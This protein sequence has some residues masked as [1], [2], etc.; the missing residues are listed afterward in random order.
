MEENCL[1]PRLDSGC[2]LDLDREFE[3]ECM[4]RLLFRLDDVRLGLA[5]LEDE[6][7]DEEVAA[8]AEIAANAAFRVPP[9]MEC[10]GRLATMMTRMIN[11]DFALK[12]CCKRVVVLLVKWLKSA[13]DILTF[14]Q[15]R[16]AP[17]IRS[18]D[19]SLFLM[20]QRKERKQ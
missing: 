11:L 18:L 14:E 9:L 4:L 2:E 7:E 6:D 1:V 15:V 12:N 10:K 13:D 19:K 16:L 17:I 20:F 8:A 3:F 5:E